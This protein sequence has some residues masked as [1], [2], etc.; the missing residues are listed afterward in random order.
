[1][2]ETPK[3]T[4]EN[5]AFMTPEA[6]ASRI[7]TTL[8]PRG[9]NGAS[10]LE[11]CCGTGNILSAC[12]DHGAG[13]VSG[14]D[15]D[16]KMLEIAGRRI[17]LHAR[18]NLMTRPFGW[19]SDPVDLAITNPPFSLALPI[20]EH[21]LGL[22]SPVRG[23]VALL[24]RLAFLEGVERTEFHLRHPCDV[25]VLRRRIRF[26]VVRGDSVVPHPKGCDR[27]AYAWFV[28]GPER[29]GRWSILDDSESQQLAIGGAV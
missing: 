23:T 24:L 17:P 25:F 5:E 22:V 2:A 27:W 1:M 12:V 7:L 19:H 16:P 21:L 6:E 10:V 14:G 20:A 4:E 3:D 29:G 9:L 13:Y 8:Y 15:I 26:G 28:W 11:P 18:A